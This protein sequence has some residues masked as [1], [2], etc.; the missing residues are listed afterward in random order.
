M[1]KDG[2]NLREF[3]GGIRSTSVTHLGSTSP[4]PAFEFSSGVSTGNQTVPASHRDPAGGSG[5]PL[6]P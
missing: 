6:G 4:G 1:I 2:L 5:L 3:A